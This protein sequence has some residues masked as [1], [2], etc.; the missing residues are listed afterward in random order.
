[1]NND[2]KELGNSREAWGS[3]GGIKSLC[4]RHRENVTNAGNVTNSYSV[5]L[6]LCTVVFLRRRGSLQLFPPRLAASASCPPSAH[7]HSSHRGPL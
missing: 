2:L 7:Q 3:G 5:R 4:L 1:M 6:S